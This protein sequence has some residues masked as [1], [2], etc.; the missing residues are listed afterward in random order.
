MLMRTDPFGELDRLTRAMLGA[1]ARSAEVPADAYRAGDRFVVELDLPGVS[2]ETIDVTVEKGVLTVR[3]ERKPPAKQTDPVV[4]E[5]AYGTFTRRLFLA[6]TLDVDR[7]SAAYDAGV[8]TV[9]VPVTERDRPR[10]IEVTHGS[11]REALRAG[12]SE[13]EHAEGG[14]R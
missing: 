11:P 7:L 13:P 14:Q 5:R 8:L 6:D 3:A 1:G 12:Q 2:P 10:R 4:S 9:T